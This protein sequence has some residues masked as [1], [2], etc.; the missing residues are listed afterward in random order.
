[1]SSLVGRAGECGALDALLAEARAGSSRAIVLRGE[2]GI[3]KSALVD[4][5]SERATN[6]HVAS[7]AGVESEMELPFSSLHQLCVTMLDQLERLPVPQRDALATIFGLSAGPAP[8]PFLVGLATLTL[9]AEVSD[10]RPLVCLIDDAQWLDHASAQIVGFVSRRLHA[11]R[12]ALVCAARSGIGHEVLAGLPEMQI[13]GL[14]I[15]DARALLL[16]SIPGPVDADVCDQLVAESHGNPLALRELPRTWN[17]TTFA[18]GY[19]LPGCH[20]VAGRIE[21]SYVQRLRQLSDESQLLILAMAAE[22][23]GDLD[24]LKRTAAGL[25]VPLEVVG[26]A[27]DAGLIAMGDRFEFAHPLVRAAVYRSATTADRHRVHDAL[28]DATD[29]KADPDRRAWHRAL[30]TIGPD[31]A[32][33]AELEQSADRALARGGLAAAAAFLR[34]A[35]EL[36]PEPF[37]RAERAL[38]AAEVD[39]QAGAAEASERSLVAIETG[40]LTELQRARAKLVRGRLAFGSEH[41][42]DAPP[43]LLDAARQLET[44]DTALA[45]DTYLEALVAAL[46][47]GRFSGAVDIRDVAKAA[48]SAPPS[49]GRASDLLLDGFATLIA[50]GYEIGAPILNHAVAAFRDEGLPLP[51]AVRWL[52]HATHAAHDVWDDEAWDE[53]CARH[54]RVARQLGAF[55]VLPLA[56]SAR[57]GFHL[58]AGELTA[59]ASLVDELASLAEAV[60]V[61]FPPYASLAL[62]AWRGHEGD[63]SELIRAVTAE[64]GPRGQGMGL[65]LVEH[66]TAVLYNGLGRYQDA[67]EAARRGAANPDELAFSMWSLAELIEAAMRTNQRVL[68]DDAL[69]R[70]IATTQPSGTNWALGVEARSHALVSD[71]A[72]AEDFYR[73]AIDRLACTRMR[74]ELARAHLLYGEWLRRE[75]R[76]IDARRELGQSHEMLLDM[77]L[78]AFA[79]RARRELVAT[80]EK[81]RKRRDETRTDL[82]PQETQIARLARDGLSNTEIGARMFLSPRTVEWHMRKVFAKLGISS[83]KQLRYALAESQ[84]GVAV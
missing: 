69:R 52:W 59:A 19:G 20:P 24:L 37:L 36:T 54:V 31:E 76:R 80:G 34:R 81:V 25:G 3:G 68:A 5:V 41:G 4:Y 8:D 48:R 33:A 27:M 46:F 63:A 14:Q 79:E 13:R 78:E 56:A 16:K 49:R 82:T 60:Q 47:I 29:P 84:T 57:V 38:R 6:W 70:L 55:A 21:Q 77:G 50:D 66:A 72:A 40:P 64:A 53:L 17:S 18:G 43:L 45:R 26:P 10:R 15:S 1:V 67:C 23:L 44:H 83:R 39:Q 28:A 32:V 30:A 7:A 35:A 62:S 74:S 73:E 9:F 42:R 12:I 75:G 22:P 58:F 11:E 2:A 71:S 65:T 61:P 51:D